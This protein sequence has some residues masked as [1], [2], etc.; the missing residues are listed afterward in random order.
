MKVK[1]SLDPIS[2]IVKP[3][4]QI[5]EISKRIAGYPVSIDIDELADKVKSRSYIL[6]GHLYE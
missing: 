4:K 3:D 2:Y 6:P 1:V 5:A